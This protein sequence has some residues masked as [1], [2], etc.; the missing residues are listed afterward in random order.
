MKV[1]PSDIW[2][3]NVW[4]T[5]LPASSPPWSSST[6]WTHSQFIH[7]Y[8]YI[9]TVMSR[10]QKK[11]QE[12]HDKRITPVWI[13]LIFRCSVVTFKWELMWRCPAPHQHLSCKAHEWC[14]DSN[15]RDCKTR[16][17]WTKIICTS[18]ILSKTVSARFETSELADVWLMDPG[19]HFNSSR[20]HVRWNKSKT[21]HVFF[22]LWHLFL[23]FFTKCLHVYTE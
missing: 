17:V 14:L 22:F 3:L 12:W 4:T 7:L 13:S 16:K 8:V 1:Q 18:E 2:S 6:S 19:R 15:E 5:K 23:V 21:L 9:Y 11:R 10:E 20:T